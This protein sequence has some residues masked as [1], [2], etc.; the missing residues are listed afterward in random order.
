MSKLKPEKLFVEYRQGISK[1]KPILKRLYTLTH[2]DETGELFLTIGNKYAFDKVSPM[3]DE[4]LGQWIKYDNAYYFYVYL[5]IDGGKIEA[6]KAEIRDKIFRQELSLALEA[7][8]YGDRGLFN[9]HPKLQNAPI[10]VFFNS[11]IEKYNRV[12]RWGAFSD[13]NMAYRSVKESGS[14]ETNILDNLIATLLNPYIEKEILNIYESN[15]KFCLKEVEIGA[16][17]EIDTGE[18]CRPNYSVT[19]GLK[20]GDNPA[21]FN[22]FIIDFSVTPDEVITKSVRTPKYYNV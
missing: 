19:V 7:I 9:A 2:S 17:E 10:I 13:F 21:P 8:R 16:I 22:N 14:R 3:R 6:D 12:E 11:S 4:V 1:D 18:S 5:L 20:V 15:K